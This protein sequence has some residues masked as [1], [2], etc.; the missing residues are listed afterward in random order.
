[1][2]TRLGSSCSSTTV[3]LYLSSAGSEAGRDA[4][5]VVAG[6]VGEGPPAGWEPALAV[7]RAAWMTERAASAVCCRIAST[8]RLGVDRHRGIGQRAQLLD[9]RVLDPRDLLDLDVAAVDGLEQR[10]ALA[11]ERRGGVER[12]LVARSAVASSSPLVVGLGE[13]EHAQLGLH[14]L[15][16]EV[17]GGAQRHLGPVAEIDGERRGVAG[18]QA[19]SLVTSPV[20]T[21]EGNL[22]TT[23]GCCDPT[24]ARRCPGAC[25]PPSG[26]SSGGRR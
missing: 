18:S 9:V 7:A 24:G 4:D 17:V 19:F 16:P 12:V 13:V 22:M 6:P 2:N 10:Q 26:S 23:N 15:A 8:V 21:I 3:A 5:A 1:M 20:P 25:P 14:G 11:Q